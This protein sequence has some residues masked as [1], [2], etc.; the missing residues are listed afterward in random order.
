MERNTLIGL[1]F[2]VM[3]FI[4]SGL[5]FLLARTVTIASFGFALAIIGALILLV[6]PEPVPDDALRALLSDS[7]RNIE[8]ILEEA[9]LRNKAYF[10]Q[11]E[12]GEIRALIPLSVGVGS[13]ALEGVALGEICR[14]PR[15]FIVS[16][17]S[18]RGLLVIP[19]GNEIVRLSRVQRGGD[20][21]EALRSTL[22]EYTD[23]AR[24]VLAVEE[25][26]GRVAKLQ[27]TKPQLN[28]DSP[29]FND[30][31]GSPVS[32]VASCV[33]AAVKGAP[34]RILEERYDPGF[35]RLTLEQ[36]EGGRGRGH[37]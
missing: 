8:I 21:E 35:I 24:G 32:C 22:V 7:I 5:G 11:M 12:D 13:K 2:L 6:V 4:I 37:R 15:R 19:P 26:D 27:I 25:D 20:L 33:T 23:L 10:M 1:E 30:S 18:V 31:L 9:G 14:A 34:I 16:R 36:V 17:G 28:S 3:G 29:Y